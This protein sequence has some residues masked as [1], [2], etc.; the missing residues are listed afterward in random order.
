[1]AARTSFAGRALLR[2]QVRLV[3]P[4]SDVRRNRADE[5]RLV[6]EL[7]DKPLRIGCQIANRVRHVC[8]LVYAEVKRGACTRTA[9]V[10]PKVGQRAP[11]PR[12]G[13]HYARHVLSQHSRRSKRRPP[14]ES[15]D[16]TLRSRYS[17]NYSVGGR[18][19]S[20]SS[21]QASSNRSGVF[22][23]SDSARQT[24]LLR[25][26][27]LCSDSES[28][29]NFSIC[30]AK[31]NTSAYAVCE[32]SMPMDFFNSEKRSGSSRSSPET[33]QLRAEP[34][35]SHRAGSPPLLGRNESRLPPQAPEQGASATSS[36]RSL[37]RPK[38]WSGVCL[39]T[40]WPT[41]S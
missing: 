8:A 23:H 31:A 35:S 15:P 4:A 38:S 7:F 33:F 26:R 3:K 12:D 41:V 9:G 25:T 24:S 17:S 22:K 39:P 32:S 2:R 10:Q 5:L 20:N 14:R 27:S 13:E 19:A 29:P 11:R 28:V 1:M 37:S 18:R 6:G 34:S 36:T 21:L 30:S 40:I 16:S